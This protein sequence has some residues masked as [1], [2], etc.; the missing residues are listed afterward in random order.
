MNI[1]RQD[2]TD[3]VAIWLWETVDWLDL[4]NTQL[5][6]DN[7]QLRAAQLLNPV[8]RQRAYELMDRDAHPSDLQD[9]KDQAFEI[10]HIERDAV[11]L[12][13]SLVKIRKEPR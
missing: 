7:T 5:R 3:P 13:K 1:E 10:C 11:G 8:D 2:L 6:S 9:L 12:I 4:E